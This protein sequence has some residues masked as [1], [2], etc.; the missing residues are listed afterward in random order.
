MCIVFEVPIKNLFPVTPDLW[1]KKLTPDFTIC[2]LQTI[3]MTP[4][5]PNRPQPIS[6]SQY[7]QQA[8]GVRATRTRRLFIT[9]LLGREALFC[10][11]IFFPTVIFFKFWKQYKF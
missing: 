3:P 2:I 5:S 8:L 10:L 7:M 1:E 9:E 4:N 11:Q 6:L